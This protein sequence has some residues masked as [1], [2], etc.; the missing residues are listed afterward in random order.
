MERL[1]SQGQGQTQSDAAHDTEEGLVTSHEHF[2]PAASKVLPDAEAL[3][4]SEKGD[5]A[6]EGAREL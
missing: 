1:K 3:G 4:D 6:G 5:R 2:E